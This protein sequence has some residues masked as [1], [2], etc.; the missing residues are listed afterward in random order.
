M[1]QSKYTFYCT[2]LHKSKYVGSYVCQAL[3]KLSKPVGDFCFE[4]VPV[5][6]G[7]LA[8]TGDIIRK[9]RMARLPYVHIDN[10]YFKPGYP[11]GYYRITKCD[12]RSYV[13]FPKNATRYQLLNVELK[14]FREGKTI[15]LCAPSELGCFVSPYS[16]LNPNEWIESMKAYVRSE[17]LKHEII[18]TH[19]Q[20]GMHKLHDVLSIADWVIGCSSNTVIDA[21]TQGV[22][23]IDMAPWVPNLLPLRREFR[24][25]EVMRHDYFTQLAYKQMKLNEFTRA[26]IENACYSD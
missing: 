5:V 21:M 23:A 17:H 26:R 8:G 16:K 11:D 18:V 25:W 19:K 4:D 6:Y 12:E 7:V 22:R 15:V 20:G 14:P 2:G 24:T 3:Q 13:Y 9:C 1:F 10:G